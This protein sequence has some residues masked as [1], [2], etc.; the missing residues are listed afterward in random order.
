[1]ADTA[2]TSPHAHSIRGHVVKLV[3]LQQPPYGA[4]L[5]GAAACLPLRHAF[6]ASTKSEFAVDIP[7]RNCEA[8]PRPRI[9]LVLPT[10]FPESYGGAEQQT[11][12]FACVLVEIGLSVTILAPRLERATPAHEKMNGITIRRFRLRAAPNLGGR[13][14]LSFLS[15]CTRVMA[16]MWWHRREFDLVHIIHARLHAVPAAAAGAILQKPVIAKLGRG[17]EHFDLSLVRKKKLIG[18]SSA[19]LLQ[20]RVTVFIANSSQ[21][22][23]DLKQ[24]GVADNRIYLIP[25]GIG[26]PDTQ[27]HVLNTDGLRRFVCLGRL[28]S[29]KNV[30]K[31]IN[32]FA[33][34]PP[35]AKA[36]LTIVGDGQCRR[37]LET[38][39]AKLQLGNCI[40]F[41]GAVDDVFPY[42]WDADFYLSTSQSEGMSNALL[43]AMSCGVVPIITNVSGATD[44]VQHELS[45]FLAPPG[46]SEFR[47]YLM[48]AL[49][50]SEAERQIMARHAV[51]TI[52]NRFGITGVAKQQLAL[53]ADLLSHRA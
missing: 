19:A 2:R 23:Q 38:L 5:N 43:E 35:E 22:A 34:L 26:L 8:P 44:I 12:R 25:N 4:K 31:M 28:D 50:L 16:W 41:A 45:G 27:R 48:R 33:A 37:E 52:E 30:D 3:V 17:G 36:R 1:M 11:R 47:H 29:E 21:I 15:W 53:Y 42:L 10:Y 14:M 9:L 24:V 51:Q 20:R 13:H 32:A 39:A 6:K 18:R 7:S 40:S 46:L 49:G